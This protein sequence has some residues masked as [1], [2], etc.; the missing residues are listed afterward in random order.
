MC[1]C[2]LGV[3]SKGS[4]EK[5]IGRPVQFSASRMGLD[6]C[7]AT[8]RAT[9]HTTG[10]QRCV[11]GARSVPCHIR[12]QVRPTTRLATNAAWM[13]GRPS[14]AARVRGR[15]P[16]RQPRTGGG[17]PARG[18]G[19]AARTTGQGAGRRAQII[20]VHCGSGGDAA[21]GAAS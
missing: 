10:Y 18:K 14:L 13:D 16:E 3:K 11:H 21:S 2:G 17:V 12:R 15:A 19:A 7:H 1:A 6:L 4:V 20:G 5:R 9:D 8:R